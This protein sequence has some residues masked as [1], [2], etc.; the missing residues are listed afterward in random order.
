MRA[1]L[2]W[3]AAALPRA[4]KFPSLD[5]MLGRKKTPRRQTADEIQAALRAWHE[6]LKGT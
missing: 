6:R 4:R 1:W 2:A 5:D 3:H